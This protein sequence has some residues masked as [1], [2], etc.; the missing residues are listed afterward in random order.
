EVNVI[1]RETD[2]DIFMNGTVSE[3]ATIELPITT[4]L[5]ITVICYDLSYTT[6][7]LN[8]TVSLYGIEEA[9]YIYSEIGTRYQYLIDSEQLGLGTHLISLVAEKQ[10][11]AQFSQLIRITVNQIQ[12]NGTI[13]DDKISSIV[14]TGNDYLLEILLK[15][16]F[17]EIIQGCEVNYTGDLGSGTL[18]YNETTKY[19]TAQLSTIP[20]GEFSVYINV[21]K[22]PNYTFERLRVTITSITPINPVDIVL[23]YLLIAAIIALVAGFGAYQFYFKYPPM[24]RDLRSIKKKIRKG[25]VKKTSTVKTMSRSEITTEILENQLRSV[26]IKRKIPHKKEEIKTIRTEEDIKRIVKPV[27]LKKDKKTTKGNGLRKEQKLEREKG[28]E[29]RVDDVE[30]KKKLE[31]KK[32]KEKELK[33]KVE[34][35]KAK[36]ERNLKKKAEKKKVKEVETEKKTELKKEKE[37]KLEKEREKQ[38]LKKEKEE[39]LEKEREKQ[40]Q[41]IQKPGKKE[42]AKVKI[43]KVKPPKKNE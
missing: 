26:R 38:K 34:K 17:G 42:D 41:K 36:E 19:Y 1:E 39:K 27:S 3:L 22:G 43:S 30:T 33:K 14:S 40:K 20:E 7:I 16:E 5:N 9:H 37:E 32:D 28:G 23:F 18:T 4:L 24:V 10:N 25:K 2:I 35:K 31:L 12:T 13:K 15:D 8:V 29:E 11:Y 6:Q 21:D